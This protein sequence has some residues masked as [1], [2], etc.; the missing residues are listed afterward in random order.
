MSTAG[1]SVCCLKMIAVMNSYMRQLLHLE[2]LHMVKLHTYF[3]C[4]TL[5]DV[6]LHMHS[7]CT[8]M[9]NVHVNLQYDSEKINV[10]VCT[11]TCTLYMLLKLYILYITMLFHIIQELCWINFFQEPLRMCR[12]FSTQKHFHC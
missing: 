9:Y 8:Y 11:C 5:V 6:G 1:W 2:A 3:Y 10:H 7:T 4:Y 12:Q